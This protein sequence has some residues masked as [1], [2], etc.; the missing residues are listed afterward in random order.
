MRIDYETIGKQD[1]VAPAALPHVSGNR[2]PLDFSGS[3]DS[4]EAVGGP[5][6]FAVKIDDDRWKLRPRCHRFGVF[7][8]D[9]DIHAGLA[10]L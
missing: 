6:G 1:R 3:S 4:M 7:R 10:H 8:N 9:A 5:I 2:F